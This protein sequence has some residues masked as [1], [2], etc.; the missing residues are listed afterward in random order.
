MK[1]TLAILATGMIALATTLIQTGAAASD[2]V[3]VAEASKAFDE[4][5]SNGRRHR[6]ARIHLRRNAY[7]Y[8]APRACNSVVFPRSPL[9]P[10]RIVTFGPY[11]PY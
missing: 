6:H 3:R 7:V 5:S 10:D 1:L 4:V 9:C 2:N 8:V 11:G